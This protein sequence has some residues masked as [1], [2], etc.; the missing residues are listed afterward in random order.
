MKFKNY[1]KNDNKIIFNIK[2]T[3]VS[4]INSIRRVILSDIPNVAFDFQPYD[5]EQK[6]VN[7]IENTCSLHNEIILQRLSMIPLKLDEN[8]IYNFEPSKYK[9]RLKK[10]NNTNKMMNVTTEHIDI[11]DENDKKYNEKFI[12]KIFPKNKLSGDFI[13]ITKLKPNLFD[14]NKGDVLEINMLASKK[15]ANYY[16]GF[17]YVSCCV[18]FNVIDEKQAKEELDKILEKNKDLSKKDIEGLEKDFNTLDKYRYFKKNEYDEPNY[19]EY[20]IESESRVSPEFL[21]FKAIIILKNRIEKLITNIIDDKIKIEKIKDT[22]NF[23]SFEIK[24]EK[25]TLGNLIQSLFYNKFVR[26]E[27]GK[28]IEYIGYH[29]PHPLDDILILKIKF[30]KKI[31]ETEINGIIIDEGLVHIQNNLDNINKKWIEISKLN[32]KL[33]D[34]KLIEEVKE[35]LS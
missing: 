17:G 11:Y 5:F 1:A 22:N 33:L 34:N 23:Y 9:F 20:N 8:E 29:C 12:R 16:A 3:D 28:I 24:N 27:E 25:H 14:K 10:V 7:I 19:F 15:N 30:N 13:L 31:K 32:K 35:Y 21:F 18:Y 6:K 4:I 26:E 2:D